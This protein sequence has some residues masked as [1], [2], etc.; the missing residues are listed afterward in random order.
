[1]DTY[2]WQR[3]YCSSEVQTAKVSGNTKKKWY[4][5]FSLDCYVGY[6]SSCSIQSSLNSLGERSNEVPSLPCQV[7]QLTFRIQA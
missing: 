4:V 5:V 1:M 2:L 3:F 6:V 7:L